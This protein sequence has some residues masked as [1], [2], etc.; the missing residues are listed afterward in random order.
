MEYKEFAETAE[1]EYHTQV[2]VNG[3]KAGA[4]YNFSEDSHVEDFRKLDHAIKAELIN[5]YEELP[6]S[7]EV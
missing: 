4:I 7:T 3:I 5:Q 2:Y 1:I 6:E